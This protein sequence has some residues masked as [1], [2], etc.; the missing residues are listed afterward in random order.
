M[1]PGSISIIY[2]VSDSMYSILIINTM[3]RVYSS[4]DNNTFS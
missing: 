2:S 1:T 4:V 3:E